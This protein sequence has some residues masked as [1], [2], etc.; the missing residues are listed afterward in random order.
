MTRPTPTA[1]ILRAPRRSDAASLRK[2]LY[3]QAFAK[4][5]HAPDKFRAIVALA[6]LVFPPA[7][8]VD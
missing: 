5:P 8:I 4:Q 7:A 6:R 2:I 3:F 1:E